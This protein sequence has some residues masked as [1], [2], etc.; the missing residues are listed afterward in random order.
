V[1][2]R[3]TPVRAGRSRASDA[4]FTL[5]ETLVGLALL[6]LAASLILAVLGTETRAQMSI[7]RHDRDV[8]EVVRAQGL[9]REQIEQMRSEIDLRGG[10]TLLTSGTLTAFDFD[11][12]IFASAGPQALYHF[13][14][15]LNS[16]GEL[17]LYNTPNLGSIDTR[18]QSTEGWQSVVL[19]TQVQALQFAY[20]GQ[21]KITG[22]DVWQQSWL[23]RRQLPKLIRLKL[24]FISGDRRIWPVLIIRPWSGMGASCPGQTDQAVCGET[25]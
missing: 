23:D 18:L 8:D 11:A 9:L 6:G 17:R 25:L 7:E 10:S 20:F 15:A 14:I 4:G 22:R 3:V 13:R 12:P 21:D 19:L 1:S 24:S 2:L 5:I 16:K